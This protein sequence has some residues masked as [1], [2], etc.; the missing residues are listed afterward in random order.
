MVF[1]SGLQIGVPHQDL[2]SL[3]VSA[4]LKQVSGETVPQHVGQ[5][6]FAPPFSL[7]K[8]DTD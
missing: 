6:A 5:D 8:S 1:S 4:I 3:Q 2:D 7:A